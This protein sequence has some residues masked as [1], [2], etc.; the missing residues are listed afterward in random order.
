[1]FAPKKMPAQAPANDTQLWGWGAGGVR[2]VIHPMRQPNK[3]SRKKIEKICPVRTTWNSSPN[4][5]F[6]FNSDLTKRGQM[7]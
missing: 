2:V 7:E 6:S 5:A 1:M 4:R 3:G